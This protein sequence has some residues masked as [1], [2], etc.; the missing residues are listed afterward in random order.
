MI[1]NARAWTFLPEALEV[2]M[3][4]RGLAIAQTNPLK[5]D[6]PAA[7]HRRLAAGICRSV[8]EA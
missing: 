5:M 4:N 2:H 1:T 8:N 3:N 7:G 6:L